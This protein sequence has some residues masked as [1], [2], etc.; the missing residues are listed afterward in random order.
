M[1]KTY[2]KLVRDR[3]PEIIRNEGRACEVTVMPLDAYQKAL[4]E[5]LVEEAREAEEATPDALVSELADILEVVDA[6]AAT[7]GLE[8]AAILAEQQVRR[9]QRGGFDE[10]L[11][12]V[13]SDA[14]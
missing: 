14:Q 4:L 2:N 6:I 7:F 12:L 5:K 1:R 3:I 11:Q 10:R 13:W 9:L 8:R